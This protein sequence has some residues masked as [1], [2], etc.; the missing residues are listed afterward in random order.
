MNPHLAQY[1][2][3][4]RLSGLLASLELRLQ[5]ARP[6]QLPHEQFL[7]L[8]FQEEINVRQQRL[9]EKRKR[10]AGFRNANK[11]LEDFDWTFNP[12]SNA[13][14]S[15]SWPPH[16]SCANTAMSSSSARL[17]WDKPS[18]PS[19]RLPGWQAGESASLGG[20]MSTAA[21]LDGGGQ[22]QP[23]RI[24]RQVAVK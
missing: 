18:G 22:P 1:A 10:D 9:V 8:I 6:H 23:S 13:S 24:W 3:Q 19:H 17:A 4:L 15:T 5:E 2:R 20:A 16:S 12:P 7:E 11:T 21:L 14:P